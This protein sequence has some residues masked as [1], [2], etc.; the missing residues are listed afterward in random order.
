VIVGEKSHLRAIEREDIPTFVRWL[1]D[2]EVR[3]YLNLYLP[4]SK[5]QEEEWFA[6]HLRD[7]SSRVFT[8]ETE[9]GVAIGN[10]GLHDLDWK[11]RSALLGIVIAEKEYWGQGYGSDAIT[12]LLRFAFGEMNLH[13]IWLAVFDFNERAI[14]CYEKCG[15]RHEGRAREAMFRDG[16]YH[17]ALQMAILQQ[18]FTGLES[19]PGGT[20]DEEV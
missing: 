1:N 5:A 19:P 4:L 2:P 6:A 15:F 16:R 18:E 11:N 17:D 14:R 7:D 20:V 12:A 3:H 10:I 13:R 8:I 9:D